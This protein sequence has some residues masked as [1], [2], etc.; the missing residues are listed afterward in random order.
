MCCTGISSVISIITR[1]VLQAKAGFVAFS[2]SS[3]RGGIQEVI[4]AKFIH[5]VVVPIIQSLLYYSCAYTKITVVMTGSAP[6]F[7]V[8]ILFG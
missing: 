7:W 3:M 5:A 6:V 2:Y 8:F 1:G 4:M